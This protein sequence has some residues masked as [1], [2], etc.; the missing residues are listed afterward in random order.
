[1]FARSASLLFAASLLLHLPLYLPLNQKCHRRL[2][3][4]ACV[5]GPTRALVRII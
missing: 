4:V 1:M 2:R 5:V 3:R